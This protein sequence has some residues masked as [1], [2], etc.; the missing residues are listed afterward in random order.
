M[1]AAHKYK[2]ENLK[3]RIEIVRVHEMIILKS[4]PLIYF[5]ICE[6]GCIFSSSIEG[7]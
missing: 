3:R 5:E 1:S 7:R 2:S 6:H 4:V